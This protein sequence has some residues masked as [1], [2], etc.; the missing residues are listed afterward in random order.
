MV[1]YSFV[2]HIFGLVISCGWNQIFKLYMNN[3][4][5][6]VG[7]YIPPDLESIPPDVEGHRHR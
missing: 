5:D 3:L 6:V 7:V 2:M 4:L 1:N